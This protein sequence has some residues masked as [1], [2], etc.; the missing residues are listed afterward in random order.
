MTPEQIREKIA[1]LASLDQDWCPYG[2]APP[3]AVAIDLASRFLPYLEGRVPP[4]ERIIPSGDEGV[5]FCWYAPPGDR[6]NTK[7]YADIEFF[8]TGEV[9][10]MIV[11]GDDKPVIWEIDPVAGYDE[12]AERITEYLRRYGVKP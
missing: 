1:A 11:A 3:N 2:T 12:A 9:V 5:A 4:P 10:A 6:I 8:N 7:V